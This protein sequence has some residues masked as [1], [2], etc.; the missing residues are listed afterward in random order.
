MIARIAGI[1]RN[2]ERIAQTPIVLIG[3]SGSNKGHRCLLLLDLIKIRVS[4][5]RKLRITAYVLRLIVRY[6]LQ[7]ERLA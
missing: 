3:S 4:R 1:D 6:S 7:I 2:R 5:T